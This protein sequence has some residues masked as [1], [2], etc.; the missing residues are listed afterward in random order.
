M[1]HMSDEVLRFGTYT[2]LCLLCAIETQVKGLPNS[3]LCRLK[4]AELLDA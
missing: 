1:I 2:R 3:V 4:A